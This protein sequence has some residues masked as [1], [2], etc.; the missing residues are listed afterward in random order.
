MAEK[1]RPA[2]PKN[3]DLDIAANV[4]VR[5]LRFEEV[6]EIA[7]VRFRGDHERESSS[8]TEREN[9]PEEVRQGVTYRDVSVRFRAASEPVDDGQAE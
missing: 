6:P 7:E 5:E 3:P 1:K 2:V 9:L 4:K 8:G